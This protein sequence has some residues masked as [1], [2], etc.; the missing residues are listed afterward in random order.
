M[1]DLKPQFGSV[2]IEHPTMDKS[3]V[4][5]QMKDAVATLSAAQRAAAA[6]ALTDTL[7]A[8]D[9]LL[10]DLCRRRGVLLAF[11]PL[12]DEIDLRG[13]LTH[14]LEQGG[15]LA[16]PV[17]EW[18]ARRMQA[19]E[20]TSLDRPE[21]TAEAHGILEP[22]EV[23]IVDPQELIGVLVP[24]LAFDANGGRLGRGAGFYDRYL[25]TL[26]QD[27]VTIGA[28]FAC[29]YIDAVPRSDHDWLVNQ[30]VCG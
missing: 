13:A 23:Q 17:S 8:A 29:Q 20:V 3:Q 11:L 21:F 26:P 10:D 16:V 5:Q 4:R 9:G 24:G 7:W 2:R 22:R 19:A 27:C 25:A 18:S 12:P 15:R 1:L 30:V 14:W 28:C 6:S